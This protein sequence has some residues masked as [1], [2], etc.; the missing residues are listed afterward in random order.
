MHEIAQ[1]QA[2]APF[3]EL[4]PVGD[5]VA[6]SV[7]I[8]RVLRPEYLAI[9][10][11]VPSRCWRDTAHDLVSLLRSLRGEANV[12]QVEKLPHEINAC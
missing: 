2:G 11:S 10:Q 12:G 3:A 4:V 1:S 5:A 7:A 6:M 8:E 9:A